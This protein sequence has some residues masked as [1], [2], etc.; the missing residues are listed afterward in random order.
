MQNEINSRTKSYLLMRRSSS[1]TDQMNKS[2][3][4]NIFDANGLISL[5]KTVVVAES[6]RGWLFMRN[7]KQNLLLLWA[8]L[9]QKVRNDIKKLFFIVGLLF[10][11]RGFNCFAKLCIQKLPPYMRQW[12]FALKEYFYSSHFM[13]QFCILLVM[14]GVTLSTPYIDAESST[15]VSLS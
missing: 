15:V 7:E 11:M 10:I 4:G 2:T 3:F 1:S 12:F 6:S 5:E 8:Q 14:T 9:M 13:L